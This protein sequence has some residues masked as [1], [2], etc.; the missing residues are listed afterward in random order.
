[1]SNKED[2]KDSYFPSFFKNSFRGNGEDVLNEPT[3][4]VATNKEGCA[5][6]RPKPSVGECDSLMQKG[7]HLGGRGGFTCCVPGCF[8][9]S[10]TDVDLSFY[11]IPNGKSK[12]NILLIKKWLHMISR[13]DFQ[14]T[15]GHRVCSKH[16]LGVR[17]TYMNN[18]PTLVPK[19]K[20]KENLKQRRVINRKQL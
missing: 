4:F 5:S 15:D 3:G 19:M 20:G 8:S 18:V 11:V 2:N 12:E 17:K 10:N 6:A 13:K 14:P 7:M 9:N 1:M 16:F